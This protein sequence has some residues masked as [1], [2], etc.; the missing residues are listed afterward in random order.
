MQVLAQMRLGRNGVDQLV[1][2]VLRVAG[3]EADLVIAG[4]RAEQVEQ[5]GEVHLLFQPLA[6][7]VDVL[8]QQGDFLIPRFHKAAELGEDIA[9]LAAL[10]AAADIRH[11]AV[12]AEVVAAVHDGQPC[13]ELALAPDAFAASGQ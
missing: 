4:H 9:G 2:G 8:A 1:A 10:F 7:A 5:I 11:D 13:A 3:H 12:G 6:I